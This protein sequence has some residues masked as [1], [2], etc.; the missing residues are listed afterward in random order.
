MLA[1]L[2]SLT[3]VIQFPDFF[4][5][6]LISEN[7]LRIAEQRSLWSNIAN[8]AITYFVALNNGRPYFE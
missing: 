8:L 6:S 2:D 1:I 7:E 4:S 3:D 5:L